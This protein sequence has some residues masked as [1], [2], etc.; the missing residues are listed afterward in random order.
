VD[1]GDNKACRGADSDDNSDTYYTV[2]GGVDSLG[3]CKAECMSATVCKG[4]EYNSAGSRCEVWTRP[5]GVG[6]STPVSG[7]TCLRHVVA[8]GGIDAFEAVDGGD[9]KACRGADS[10]D[11]SDTYYTVLGGVDSLGACKAECM[12]ATVCKGI[13]YNSAGSRCEVWTRPGGIGATRSASGFTCQRYLPAVPRRMSDELSDSQK[14]A[15]S[16]F[17]LI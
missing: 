11:N 14:P 10:D 7:F 4:I 9:N 8:S 5:G 15:S 17:W 12:S 3:A 1:G 13:E 6:A 16:S 2:L